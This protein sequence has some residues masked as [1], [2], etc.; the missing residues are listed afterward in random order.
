MSVS[1]NAV[2]LKES[3]KCFD[4]KD[5]NQVQSEPTLLKDSILFGKKRNDVQ[6]IVHTNAI[7]KIQC[8]CEY[9]DLHPKNFGISEDQPRTV[10]ISFGVISTWWTVKPF[11]ED[12]W[13]PRTR[14]ILQFCSKFALEN[15]LLKLPMPFLRIH[16]SVGQ[17]SWLEFY[18]LFQTQKTCSGPWIVFW[19]L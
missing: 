16:L 14:R 8:E 13:K 10:E 11:S 18:N 12:F 4:S 5:E 19:L 1:V 15:V 7:W 17:F 2:N 9:E 3:K 6:N